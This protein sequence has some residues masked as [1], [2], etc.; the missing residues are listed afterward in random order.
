MS[1][2]PPTSHAPPPQAWELPFSREDPNMSV[3]LPGVVDTIKLLPLARRVGSYV[4]KEHRAGRTPI[5]DLNGIT[6]SPPLPRSNAGVPLGGIGGGA[7]GRGFRGEFRRW[8]ITP[9]R[10]RHSVIAGNTFSVRVGGKAVVLSMEAANDIPRSMKTWTWGS[11]PDIDLAARSTYHALFPRSWTVYSDPTNSNSRIEI[12]SKQVS[13][14]IPDNY[15]DS[16]LPTAVFEFTIVNSGDKDEDVSLMFT[17]EN[18]DGGDEKDEA[19]HL[20]NNSSTAP[21]RHASTFDASGGNGSVVESAGIS[22]RHTRR[23]KI[24]FEK[25]EDE[26]MSTPVKEPFCSCTGPLKPPATYEEKTT[27]AMA[28]PGQEDGVDVSASVGFDPTNAVACEQLWTAFANDGRL[29]ELNGDVKSTVG[30]QAS[31]LCQ[32]T[33]VK[34]NS[35]VTLKFSLSWDSPL[36]IFGCGDGLPRRHSIFFPNPASSQSSATAPALATIALTKYMSWESEIDAWQ[37]PV[38]TSPAVPSWFKNQLFNELYYLTDGGCVWVDST[39]ARK[40]DRGAGEGDAVKMDR[41]SGSVGDV[42]ILAVCVAAMAKME[43]INKASQTA[44]GDSAVIGE[45]L[46]LEGH[47]YIMYNTSDVHFYASFALAKLFPQIQLSVLRDFGLS[48]FQEDIE[49]RKLLGEGERALRKVNGALVHDLGSPSEYPILKVNAYNFQDVSRWKDL[50][51]KFVLMIVREVKDESV[52]KTAFLKAVWPA[53]QSCMDRAATL[54]DSDNTGM[55]KNEGFPDQTYDVWIADGVSAYTGGLW[56]AA[57][58]GMSK[59]AARMED[60]ERSLS[61]LDKAKRAKAIYNETLWNGEYYN[62]SEKGRYNSGSIMAD[63]LC[64]QWWTRICG[65]ENV[66]DED[67]KAKSSLRK[68]HEYNVVRWKELCGGVL[69]GA[70]NGMKPDGTVDSSCLQSMEVW[71]GTT[72]GLA[73]EFLCEASAIKGDSEEEKKERAWLWNAGFETARGVK[74]A[75]WEQYGFGFATPEAWDRNG[76]Y[77]SLGYMRP[78]SIWSMVYDMDLSEEW[79]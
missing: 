6:L 23:R 78:L 34:A 36:A 16:S 27:F 45:F 58:F 70:V 73:S 74:E 14:F 35:S 55:I 4:Y 68:I 38:L 52:D 12:T 67:V 48:V 64:G 1:Y 3:S 21:R 54:W 9:G 76:A 65:L 77:R 69:N 62:Y 72:Y 20:R 11:S 19:E 39:Q 40:N 31:A 25:G 53:M 75:G 47:E 66:C 18:N 33:T 8:S 79:F 50:P 30:E 71:T 46:Y 44:Q 60:M 5:F 49:E 10:Y 63:Q 59:I 43:E 57:L 56:V 13:P 2:T 37:G 15:T 41:N 51:S 26:R 17:F 24:A 22:M 29:G 32:K 42:D 28:V 7:I 61:Y